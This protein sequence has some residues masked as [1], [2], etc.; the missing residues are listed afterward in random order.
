MGPLFGATPYRNSSE[1]DRKVI[2]V[3]KTGADA[4]VFVS[5]SSQMTTM[6]CTLRRPPAG[7]LTFRAGSSGG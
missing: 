4:A 5:L 6:P 2:P 1:H 3:A 7:V